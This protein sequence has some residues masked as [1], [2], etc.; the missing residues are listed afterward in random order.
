MG[1]SANAL[2]LKLRRIRRALFDC[3]NRRLAAEE[4]S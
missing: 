2:Y 4:R 1:I 3:I